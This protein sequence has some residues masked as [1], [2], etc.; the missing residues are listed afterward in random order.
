MI[1]A[2]V[3]GAACA[4]ALS[5]AGHDVHV[6]DK[7]RGPGGRLATRRAEWID[8]RGQARVTRFDHG[9][10]GFTA[11]TAAFASF[12]NQALAD[13]NL[14]C[15][16]PVAALAGQALDGSLPYYLPLPDMPALCR[17][18]LAGSRAHWASNVDALLRDAQGWRLGVEGQARPETFDAVVLALPPAQAA[19]LLAPHRRDWAQRAA[20]AL[21]QPCWT[22]MAVTDALADAPPWDVARPFAGPLAWIHRSDARPGRAGQPGEA[23]WVVHARAGWSR[24]HLEQSP[25]WVEAQLQAGLATWLGQPLAWRFVAAH[26][27]RY[28]N[29]HA[30]SS[31]PDGQCWW[32]AASGLGACGDFLG[33]GG[34]E[35]AWLSAQ[36]LTHALLTRSATV[37]LATDGLFG[38]TAHRAA[39]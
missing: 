27:W 14:Q 4:F 3:A 2:G 25:A 24:E 39:A 21:M 1:G 17:P 22:L 12:A 35:G 9:A 18:L 10:S 23:H 36:S 33:G 7:S 34:V 29:V 5:E 31:T 8:A 37:A 15:W 38:R 6:F 26:R 20:L 13:G 19:A 32:D 16:A 11:T 28:A 30:P